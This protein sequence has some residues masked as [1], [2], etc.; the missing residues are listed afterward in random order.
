MLA[1]QRRILLAM[2]TGTGKTRTAIGLM[3]RLLKS[4]RFSRIPFLIDRNALGEQALEAV[5]NA[6]IVQFQ[7]FAKIYDVKG[8]DELFPEPETRLQIATIQA[9]IGRTL[10]LAT[11]LGDL[12][13]ALWS[14]AS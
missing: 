10:A 14:E 12:Q 8:M 1:G 5:E 9:M 13:D 3:V 11:V 7:T 6:P 4:R 2:A